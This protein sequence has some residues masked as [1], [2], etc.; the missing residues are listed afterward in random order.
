MAIDISALDDAKLATL[1]V[2]ALRIEAA[3]ASPKQ[4]EATE[5]LSQ[6]NE[7]LTRRAEQKSE[8]KAKTAPVKKASTKTTTA[9]KAA[10]PK[11]SRAAPKEEAE[12][13]E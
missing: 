4:Q 10:A 5:M 11:T 8:L 7:E 12:D 6:I 9:K 13:E 1:R 3:G 2:N